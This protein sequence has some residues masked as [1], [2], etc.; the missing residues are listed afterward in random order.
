[1]EE[2]THSPDSSSPSKDVAPG[3]HSLPHADPHTARAPT[4]THH[5]LHT[6][7]PPH[8]VNSIAT[9]A[10]YAGA[11]SPP[12]HEHN[13]HGEHGHRSQSMTGNDPAM[14]E[15]YKDVLQDIEDL[16]CARLSPELFQRRWSQNCE[17]EDPLTK[18]HGY[19]ECAAQFFGLAKLCSS[20]KRIS[21]R[22]VSATLK[23]NKLVLAQTQEYTIRLFG[24]KKTVASFVLVTLDE[25]YKIT[26]MVDQWDGNELPTR[27]GALY[28][29]RFA[30]VLIRWFVTV[31]KSTSN[32]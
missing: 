4:L 17:Y 1:M 2:T 31:P 29:R 13:A 6:L 8:F 28:L 24:T 30:A 12:A 11:L 27:W 22:V 32:S 9:G 23:P 10:H 3:E 21:C 26:K 16:F 18:A 15:L 20:S 5:N 25:D 7:N 14:L 19:L